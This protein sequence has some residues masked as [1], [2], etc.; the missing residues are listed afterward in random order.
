[1]EITVETVLIFCNLL[2]T[3]GLLLYK[4]IIQCVNNGCHSD[5]CGME[6]TVNPTEHGTDND[7]KGGGGGVGIGGGEG[8]MGNDYEAGDED[9]IDAFLDSKISDRSS[10][11]R[12]TP[13]LRNLAAYLSSPEINRENMSMNLKMRAPR[14]PP[15]PSLSSRNS[16]NSR[17]R[18]SSRAFDPL[19]IVINDCNSNSYEDDSSNVQKKR[20]SI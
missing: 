9:F 20:S 7:A 18:L 11:L 1:M 5:C 12:K 14:A 15:S 17:K 8:G 10:G 6:T 13:P 2:L 16:R 4:I 19:E 3:L